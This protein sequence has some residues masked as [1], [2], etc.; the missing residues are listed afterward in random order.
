MLI[1]KSILTGA[2]AA[3]KYITISQN[4]ACLFDAIDTQKKLQRIIDR[5][6]SVCH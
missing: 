5:E 2:S 6:N 1:F 4:N 3:T